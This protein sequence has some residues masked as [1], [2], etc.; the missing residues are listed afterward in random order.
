MV[1]RT[2][3]AKHLLAEVDTELLLTPSDRRTK[4]SDNDLEIAAI[5]LA[6]AEHAD[7]PEQRQ[8]LRGQISRLVLDTWSFD[9]PL[10]KD[11]VTFDD[12]FLTR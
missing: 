2:D 4:A 6:A 7:A 11:L 1:S 12:G 3:T 5:L 10:S 8:V 9:A